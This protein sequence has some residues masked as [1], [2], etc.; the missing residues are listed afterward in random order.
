[1]RCDIK[2]VRR[3]A[4]KPGE[5]AAEGESSA[6]VDVHVRCGERRAGWTSFVD[7][8]V[9]NVNPDLHLEDARENRDLFL[10]NTLLIEAQRR[11]ACD[12]TR[13]RHDMSEMQ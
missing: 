9:T 12:S 3:A 7:I 8:V 4:T 13:R 6:K 5:I 1:M 2:L 11:I 10:G